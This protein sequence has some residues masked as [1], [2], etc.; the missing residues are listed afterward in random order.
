MSSLEVWGLGLYAYSGVQ[1]SSIVLILG[2]KMLQILPQLDVFAI[3]DCQ[4][5][6]SVIHSKLPLNCVI[7]IVFESIIEHR[8][9][10]MLV[11]NLSLL[12]FKAQYIQY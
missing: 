6:F 3:C 1:K 9:N 7:I 8:V 2:A 4:L 5:K 11:I 10:T 12:A